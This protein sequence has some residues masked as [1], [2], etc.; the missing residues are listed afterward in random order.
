MSE[1]AK[2]PVG[3]M[4]RVMAEEFRSIP[5]ELLTPDTRLD[6]LFT[7]F[8]L[9]EGDLVSHGRPI[10]H[11]A[12]HALDDMQYICV[13]AMRF[14][15]EELPYSLQED[16][17]KLIKIS[18]PGLMFPAHLPEDNWL[19]LRARYSTKASPA[20]SRIH[21][22]KEMLFVH[23]DTESDIQTISFTSAALTEMGSYIDV[24]E[25]ISGCPAREA[26][27]RN[28]VALFIDAV[29]DPVQVQKPTPYSQN[30]PTTQSLNVQ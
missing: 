8:N 30:Y 23:K 16:R 26:I 25:G 18:V 7:A 10:L 13:G 19:K 2:S 3:V 21:L 20:H 28:S 29:F 9:R 6:H 4:Q 17:K 22:S 12:T 15:E 14:A 24:R 11:L 27:L 5:P 1:F